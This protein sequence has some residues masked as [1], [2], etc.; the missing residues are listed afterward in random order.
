[1]NTAYD[2]TD[3]NDFFVMAGGAGAALAGLLFVAVSFNHEQILA[4]P[5]LPPCPPGPWAR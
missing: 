3:W 2:A 5:T 1:M 4:N